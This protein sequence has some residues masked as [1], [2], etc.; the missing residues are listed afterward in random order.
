MG[1]HCRMI[2]EPNVLKSV[3]LALKVAATATPLLPVAGD[4]AL[5]VDIVAAIKAAPDPKPV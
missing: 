2:F 1:I 3:R 4:S 5:P